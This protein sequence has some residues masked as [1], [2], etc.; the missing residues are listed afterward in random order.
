MEC[1]C[2]RARDTA[3]L[4]KLNICVVVVQRGSQWICLFVTCHNVCTCVSVHVSVC[5][6]R[7]WERKSAALN[8]AHPRWS[9]TRW[10][11]EDANRA[12]RMRD[13]YVLCAIA[14]V[15][16]SP[17]HSSVDSRKVITFIVVQG[18]PFK[19]SWLDCSDCQIPK[20]RCDNAY[21]MCEEDRQLLLVSV[22]SRSAEC[23]GLRSFRFTKWGQ[24]FVSCSCK[25]RRLAVYI[26]LSG[27]PIVEAY[28]VG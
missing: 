20:H 2:E 10:L 3:V 23:R 4:T 19:S 7:R 8:Q 6:R 16:A 21:K 26:L 27:A 11:G 22:S 28:L 17:S 13:H 18:S 15:R 25:R 1:L 14:V 12:H 24:R 5:T 9:M